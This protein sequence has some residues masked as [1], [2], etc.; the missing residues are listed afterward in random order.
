M[1]TPKDF[2]ER[3]RC[4]VCKSSDNFTWTK[5]SYRHYLSIRQDISSN[6]DVFSSIPKISDKI[7]KLKRCSNCGFVFASPQ[8]KPISL[9][10]IYNREASYFESYSDTKSLAHLKRQSTFDLEVA[11]INSL[12]AGGNILDVGCNGGYFL[13]KLGDIW[14]KTG[15]EI[16]PDAA[17]SAEKLLRGKAKIINSELEKANLKENFFDCVVIRGTIEHVP[18]PERT[19]KTIFKL[20]KP[21]GI[22]AI[23]TQNIDSFAAKLYRQNF[24]LLDPIHH[25]WNF[26]P[27]T[28]SLLCHNIGFNIEKVNFNYFNTPYF[29][30]IDLITVLT[31]WI[32]FWLFSVRPNRVSPPFYGN[33][34]DI[35]ARKPV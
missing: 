26:S 13:N 8:I 32:T 19:L 18:D 31:D 27:S 9:S 25:I 3:K 4:I 24:R 10:K 1:V 7:I 28:I 15:V 23:N 22:V 6:P 17:K 30:I 21:N 29:R 35:Y 14:K 2:I 34:M 33:I 20:L 11:K 12:S 16:D 5:T